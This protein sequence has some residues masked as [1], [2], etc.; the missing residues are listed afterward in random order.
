MIELTWPTDQ[1]PIQE[2]LHSGRHC[3]FYNP[4]FDRRLLDHQSG[5][6]DLCDWAN[7]QIN[8]QGLARFLQDVH[9]RDNIA[10][11]VK[12]NMWTHDIRRQGIVKPMLIWYFGAQQYSS[13]TGHSRLR[14]AERIPAITHVSAFISTSTLY[15]AEFSNLE[16]VTTMAR[17]AELCGAV[18]GQRF[19]FRLGNLHDP[20]GLDWFEYDSKRTATVTP[21]DSWCIQALTQYLDQHPETQ[22]TPEW[23]DQP[24]AWMQ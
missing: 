11:L 24:I 3:L 9:N 8:C 17:F 15:Q 22:F 6:A 23:F 1:D 19:L 5:L 14:A 16:S 7:S 20:Y 4:K 21:G 10:N 13:A 2:S 12:L 18:P